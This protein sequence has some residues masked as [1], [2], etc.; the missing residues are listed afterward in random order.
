MVNLGEYFESGKNPILLMVA[1]AVLGFLFFLGKYL[2]IFGFIFSILGQLT[3]VLGFFVS[4]AAI[5][6]IGYSYAK[7]G[8][9]LG[10]SA[11]AA[12]L[13]GVINSAAVG[14]LGVFTSVINTL[15]PGGQDLMALIQLATNLP[16]TTMF[17]GFGGVLNV[18]FAIVGL[19]VGVIFGA[20]GGVLLGA[21]G[22]FLGGATKNKK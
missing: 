13:G 14:V 18:V 11:A 4:I 3:G 16:I 12:S 2:P 8:G 6:Y 17:T 19:F 20:I 10:G 7:K 15:F 21:I 9:S 5:T 1:F 22:G